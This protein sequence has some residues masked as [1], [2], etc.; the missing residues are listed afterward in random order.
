MATK[1]IPEVIDELM[2]ASYRFNRLNSPDITPER[3]ATVFD[4]AAAYENAFQT[5]KA[6]EY[7]SGYGGKE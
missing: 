5:E 6:I 7:L 4:N 2:Y 3:W 1:S